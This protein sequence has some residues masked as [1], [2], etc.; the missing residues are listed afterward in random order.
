M[1]PA[2]LPDVLH[3]LTAFVIFAVG[4]GM[5]AVHT[6]L[7]TMAAPQ[8]TRAR[9]TPFLV[10]AAVGACLTLWF[11]LAI[12]VG[13]RTNFP[14]EHEGSR[15]WLSLVVGFGPMFVG[16]AMLFASKAIRQLNAA[17]PPQ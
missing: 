9:R 17:M 5:I 16:I 13:D 11:S 15:L 12:A 10:A 4:M 7:A 8:S 6:A 14:L 3:R 2:E 1:T